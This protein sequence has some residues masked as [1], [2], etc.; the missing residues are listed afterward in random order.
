MVYDNPQA[1]FTEGRTTPNLNIKYFVVPSEV[2]SYSKSKL[3]QLDRTAEINLV[4]H[5][6]NECENEAMYKRQLRE[7]A[8]GWF[9]QDPEKMATAEAY[10]MP[11]CERLEKL[12][13]NR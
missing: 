4:R 3:T 13:V 8:M 2:A 7:N 5:L 9:F 10:K 6:R 1:P 11:S 12:N